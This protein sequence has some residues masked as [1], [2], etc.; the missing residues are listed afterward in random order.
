MSDYILVMATASSLEEGEGI[1]KAVVG[2]KLAACCNIIPEIRS[3]YTWKGEV[4]DEREVMLIMKS[5]ASLF[6]ALKERV[7]EL[8]SYEVPEVI[9]FSIE[10]GLDEYLA[11]IGSVTK[12]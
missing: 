11:W 1:A 9:S 6:T 2:E 10:T 7:R 12:G 8:H 5:R 4:C 3:I